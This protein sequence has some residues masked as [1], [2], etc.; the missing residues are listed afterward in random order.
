MLR[1]VRVQ[2]EGFLRREHYW[3]AVGNL[4]EWI[5]SDKPLLPSLFSLP[6]QPSPTH[7]YRRAHTKYPNICRIKKITH[8]QKGLNELN[9]LKFKSCSHICWTFMLDIR[10]ANQRNLSLKCHCVFQF[11]SPVNHH[12][13]TACNPSCKKTPLFSGGGGGLL[14]TTDD[15][16]LIYEASILLLSPL[17]AIFLIDE[18]REL[19]LS[20]WSVWWLC[21]IVH[22]YGCWLAIHSSMQLYQCHKGLV[23]KA[24]PKMLINVSCGESIILSNPWR[25]LY[26]GAVWNRWCEIIVQSSRIVRMRLVVAESYRRQLWRTLASKI[27]F[28]YL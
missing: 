12:F 19:P 28:L 4:Y 6:P 18:V 11:S 3:E 24:R 7:S 10:L 21:N 2:K 1:Q 9:L 25:L 15:C 16:S 27:L 8:R 22:W 13:E 26:R 14:T 5:E 20:P 17:S 23:S